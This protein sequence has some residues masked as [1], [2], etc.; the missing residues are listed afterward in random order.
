MIAPRARSVTPSASVHT[1]TTPSA[2]RRDDT[3]A[4]RFAPS[5]WR[6]AS[7][8]AVAPRTSPA[9]ASAS[10]ALMSEVPGTARRSSAIAAIDGRAERA[11]AAA[12][13]ARTPSRTQLRI[14]ME[15]HT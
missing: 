2:A 4:A 11:G 6:S 10:R 12:C 1:P 9:A 14:D 7:S 5:F 15:K 13:S 8:Q 3:L